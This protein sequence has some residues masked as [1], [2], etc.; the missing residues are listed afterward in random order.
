MAVGTTG[1]AVYLVSALNFLAAV[2]L[3]VLRP[4]TWRGWL[5]GLAAG[6][7]WLIAWLAPVPIWMGALL[8]LMVLWGLLAAFRQPSL[9]KT[10]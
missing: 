1:F 8:E 10:V 9:Q 6:A 5:S 7:A 4:L 2:I 3:N